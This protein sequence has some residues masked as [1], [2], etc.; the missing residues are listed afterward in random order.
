MDDEQSDFHGWYDSTPDV[1]YGEQH[2]A[3][4]EAITKQ[5]ANPKAVL[6]H[7]WEHVETMPLE[8]SA[9]AH[10]LLTIAMALITIIHGEDE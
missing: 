6:K 9:R 2:N 5:L 4:Q 3:D 1:K 10:G 7:M 8:R